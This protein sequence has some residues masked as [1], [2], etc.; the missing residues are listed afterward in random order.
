MAALKHAQRVVQ[1]IGNAWVFPSPEDPT[2]YCSQYIMRD[3][4]ERGLKKIGITSGMRYGWHSLRRQFATDLTHIPL[5]DLCALGGWKDPNT[6]LKC[7]AQ[8]DEQTMR[9]ALNNR[10]RFAVNGR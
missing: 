5:S 8:P 9:E 6:I 3:W 10:T 4:M 7:Y 1:V 2:R